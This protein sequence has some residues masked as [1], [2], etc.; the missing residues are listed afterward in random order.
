M[1][2]M[3]ALVTGAAARVRA[4]GTIDHRL[5]GRSRYETAIAVSRWQ[6]PAGARLVFLARGDAY[7]DAVSAGAV[8]DGPTLLVPRTGPV[9]DAVLAEV[10]RLN[11]EWV[12][13]LGGTAAISEQVL[14][15][16]AAGRHPFRLGGETRFDTAVA[17]S[18]W[19]FAGGASTVFLARADVS[20]DA[21]AGGVLTAGPILLVPAVGT[22]PPPVLN[23]LR[24]L[25]PTRVI[26]L[27]GPAAISD[28][29]LASAGSGRSQSRLAGPTRYDTAI[30]IARSQFPS[31]S[32][33]V[34]LA[35]GDDPVDGIIA[36]SLTDGPVLLVAPGCVPPTRALLDEVARLQPN[37]TVVVGGPGAV[38]DAA[39]GG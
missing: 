6:F 16:A 38:C 2:L 8:T 27:G 36:G 5:W 37:E 32:R 34:Y 29:V 3:L 25:N 24:R 13:A 26:A 30:A 10:R 17:I 4:A 39:L 28:A 11:P 19:Q 22:V 14:N 21:V 1:L 31:G 18:Q 15:D 9:P 7:A 23:E 33:R 12:I 20:A 35:R